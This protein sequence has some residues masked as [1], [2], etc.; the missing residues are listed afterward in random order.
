M[1]EEEIVKSVMNGNAK[2]ANLALRKRD[3]QDISI[4]SVYQNLKVNFNKKNYSKMF[5]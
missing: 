4:M 2:F 5:P 1:E 3:L